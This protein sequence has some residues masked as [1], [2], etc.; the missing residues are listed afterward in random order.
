MPRRVGEHLPI[1]L[2]VPFKLFW[3]YYT[4]RRAGHPRSSPS[5][6]RGELMWYNKGGMP[7]F[8]SAPLRGELVRYNE[9]IVLRY[10]ILPFRV[11][12]RIG[13]FRPPCHQSRYD[14]LPFMVL[15]QRIDKSPIRSPHKK[16]K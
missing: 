7:A 6:L 10:D 16:T 14:I 2:G 1:R 12:I 13:K 11:L 3:F 9:G 4:Q 15:I 8:L 5:P